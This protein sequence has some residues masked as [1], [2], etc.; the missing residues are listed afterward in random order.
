M[1]TSSD[2]VTLGGMSGGRA[3]DDVLVVVV[4]YNSAGVVADLFASLEP[5]M[6]GVAHRVVVAD[7]ASADG[8]ADLVRRLAPDAVVVETGRNGGYAA[9]IN[10]AVAAGG[11]AYRAILVL[12]PDVRLQPGCVPALLAGLDRPGTGV[13]VP[14]LVDGD[15]VLVESMRREPSLTR[16]A[17]DAVLGARRAGRVPGLGEVVMDPELYLRDAR[18]DWA[19][20]STQLVSAECW[21]RCGPWQEDYFLYSEETDF[22]LRARDAGLGTLFVADA[23]AVHLGGE[24]TTSPGLWSL[25]VANKLRLYRRRHSWPAT[26]LFW[27][28]LTAR[29]ASRAATGS[30]VAREALRVLLSPTALRRE[31]G[32]AWL[33]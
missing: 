16:T 12:N 33:A 18:T 4:T 9:G 11:P 30:A 26:A 17:A 1:A 29:E 21:R 13:T 7:N 3:D 32:P 28:A 23:H 2:A 14:R 27:C 10:A 19:E 25:L 31:R 15:G 8:T 6:A 5:G 24:S 20:G 22:G